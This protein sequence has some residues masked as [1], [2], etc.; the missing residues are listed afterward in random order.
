MSE[1]AKPPD[2]G[3]VDP[4]TSDPV[5]GATFSD[6]PFPCPNCGQM[7]A[8]DVRICAVCKRTIDPAE[9]RRPKP[10]PPSVGPY[11]V[12]SAPANARFSWR[13]LFVVLGASLL[14]AAFIQRFWGQA[15][16]QLV[17]AGV[18]IFSSAW[19]FFDAQQRGVPQ[20]LRWGLGSLVLWPVLFPWYLARRRTPKA[21][22]PFVEAKASPL[23][24]TVLFALMI[25]FLLVVFFLKEP[26]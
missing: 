1:S 11:R 9:I 24:R 20:P 7:L 18:Q 10:L 17:M 26:K 15:E 23:A 4:R 21:P 14:A 16:S 6:E 19:V 25:V 13:I 8:P 2:S 12:F 5:T 22:C 3:N